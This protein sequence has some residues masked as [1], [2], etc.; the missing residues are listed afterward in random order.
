[1]KRIICLIITLSIILSFSSFAADSDL[2]SW[3]APRKTD[4]SYRPSD[5]YVSEQNPPSFTWPYVDDAY[6]YQLQIA[7]DKNF[8]SI[9]TEK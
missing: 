1:M 5:N 9:C 3:P 2:L 7:E 6:R 8:E 4:A